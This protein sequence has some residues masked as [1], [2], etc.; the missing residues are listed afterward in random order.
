MSRSA[1]QPIRGEIENSPG[2]VSVKDHALS[3]YVC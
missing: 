3:Y 1:L 2:G